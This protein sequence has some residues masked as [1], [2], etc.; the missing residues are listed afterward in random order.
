M[1]SGGPLILLVD[2]DA[3]SRGAVRASLEFEGYSVLEVGNG[4]EALDLLV[5][6]GATEP[7]LIVLDIQMPVMTGWEFLAIIKGYT[8]LARLPVLVVSGNQQAHPEA[9]ASGAIAGYLPKPFELD[10]LLA[11]VRRALVGRRD[12]SH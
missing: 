4:K 8:R 11:E 7:A 12:P 9:W 10:R 5:A 1:A 6:E 2:D 3:D